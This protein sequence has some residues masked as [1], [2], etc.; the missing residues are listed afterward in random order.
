MR[1]WEQVRIVSTGVD[2]ISAAAC[3]FVYSNC[4]CPFIVDI[5]LTLYIFGLCRRPVY[6][7]ILLNA[8]AQYLD[9]VYVSLAHTH[10]PGVG[11]CS[12]KVDMESIRRVFHA[13]TLS[14]PLIGWSL[15]PQ[16]LVVCRWRR[17][18]ASWLRSLHTAVTLCRCATGLSSD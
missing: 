5:F 16:W 1:Q 18:Y 9:A 6:C 13:P 17:V 12:T 15:R 7:T 3:A 8:H 10:V 14:S 11:R 2:V 4:S